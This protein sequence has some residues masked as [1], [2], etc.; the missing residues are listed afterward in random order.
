[1][2]ALN[3]LQLPVAGGSPQIRVTTLVESDED[4]FTNNSI[5]DV[6]E[7]PWPRQTS[8]RGHVRPP[9]LRPPIAGFDNHQF[10]EQVATLMDLHTPA[11]WRPTT[12][13]GSDAKD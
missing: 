9:R 7:Y 12:C 6:D 10:T 3:A 5:G 13:A 4:R 8:D 1:M 11:G 2:I